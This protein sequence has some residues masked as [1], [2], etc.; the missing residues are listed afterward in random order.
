MESL[1][2]RNEDIVW[3]RIE[4]EIVAIGSDGFTVHVLNKTAAYI[5][6]LCDGTKS[7]DEIAVCLCECYDVAPDEAIADVQ[8]TIG[9]FEGLGLLGKANG[10]TADE[11]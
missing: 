8:D 10:V 7:L 3:R 9:K 1:V 11:R 4:D 6:D 2:A 5:W